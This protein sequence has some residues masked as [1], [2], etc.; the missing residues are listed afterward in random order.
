[1][2]KNFHG[3]TI[4]RTGVGDFISVLRDGPLMEQVRKVAAAQ[5]DALRNGIREG[6]GPPP[7]KGKS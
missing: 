2:D 4:R 1:M 3:L 7:K 6:A 5:R